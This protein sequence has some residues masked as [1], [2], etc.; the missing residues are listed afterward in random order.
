METSPIMREDVEQLIDRY[1]LESVLDHIKTYTTLFPDLLKGGLRA[2]HV[3]NNHN[4]GFELD[5]VHINYDKV[6][7]KMVGVDEHYVLDGDSRQT[8]WE[9]AKRKSEVEAIQ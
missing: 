7:V 5:Y 3:T 2:V 9:S 1:G 8:T 6:K 4:P